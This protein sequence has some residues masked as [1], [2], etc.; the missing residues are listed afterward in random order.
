MG[1]ASSHPSATGM[2]I[3]SVAQSGCTLP[4]LFDPVAGDGATL[5]HLRTLRNSTW[6]VQPQ[7]YDGRGKQHP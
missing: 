7:P 3:T 6:L 1:S 5:P 4:M 2:Y